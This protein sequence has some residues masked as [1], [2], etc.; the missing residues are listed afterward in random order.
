[1][2]L[3][4]CEDRLTVTPVRLPYPHPCAEWTRQRLLELVSQ[5]G[6]RTL[7]IDFSE[8]GYVTAEELGSLVLVQKRIIAQGGRL[9][10]SCM[11]EGVREIFAVTRLERT[12]NIVLADEP[13]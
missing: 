3:L 7:E 5:A 1:M 10:L 2:T 12:F 9:V 8:A 11:D 6:S 4:E 13:D